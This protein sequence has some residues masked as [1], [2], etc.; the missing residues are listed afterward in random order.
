M[1]ATQ[2]TVYHL[3]PGTANPST[4]KIWAGWPD[5]DT[6]VVNAPT[7][8]RAERMATLDPGLPPDPVLDQPRTLYKMLTAPDAETVASLLLQSPL[9]VPLNY[10]IGS[11]TAG[12]LAS[13]QQ[14]ISF[15]A[16]RAPFRMNEYVDNTPVSTL[17]WSLAIPKRY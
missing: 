9:G 4:L 17:D 15:T 11:G 14:L 5:N 6:W 8:I 7:V 13:T 3:Q 1:R 10:M 2:K 16:G 12:T